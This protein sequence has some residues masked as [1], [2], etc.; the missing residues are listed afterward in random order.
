MQEAE[1]RLPDSLGR[2]HRRRLQRDGPVPSVPRRPSVEIYGVEAAG[3][4]LD[5]RQH[6]ASIAGGRP[7][8]L[9]GNRTYLLH[10]RRRPDQGGAFDLGRARLSRHR[11][12]AF[13][14]ARY[15]AASPICRRPTTRRWRVPALLQARRHHPGAGAGARHR[16][17]DRT[18]AEKP[19]DHLMVINLSGR[20][21]KDIDTVAGICGEKRDDHPHRSPLRRAEAT[22]AAPRWSPSLMA[23]DPDPATSLAI[24][25]ALPAGRRRRDRDRHAVHRSDGRR[26]GDPGGGPA[27]AQAGQTM[28]QDAGRWCANSAPATTRRRS[29]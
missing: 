19:K 23:G 20:G 18:R 17:G 6:A 16:Q 21:D 8:V 11:A 10:G 3:H 25:K 13:L 24:L 26:A 1:G 12:G 5:D 7:G 28:K 27:R 15:R 14:A 22:K 29:C 4:G 9:H 2:L